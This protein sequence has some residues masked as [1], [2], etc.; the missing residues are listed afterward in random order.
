M[1]VAFASETHNFR[2]VL[3]SFLDKGSW[4]LLRLIFLMY[5]HQLS[6]WN[7][8][9]ITIRVFMPKFSAVVAYGSC[10]AIAGGGLLLGSGMQRSFTTLW[11]SRFI[12]LFSFYISLFHW[13]F[14]TCDFIKIDIRQL[15]QIPRNHPFKMHIR[16]LWPFFTKAKEVV[17][18]YLLNFVFFALFCH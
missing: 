11:L 1:S 8:I 3:V 5:F 9:I 7:R 13:C 10:C 15:L 18:T 6:P 17:W 2:E 4:W 14:F 12:F 16:T